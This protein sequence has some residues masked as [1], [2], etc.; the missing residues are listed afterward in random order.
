M[1]TLILMC[2]LL[3]L[4]SPLH[5]ES[6]PAHPL[7]PERWLPRLVGRSNEE[8]RIGGHFAVDGACRLKALFSYNLLK[9]ASHGDL[10]FR[11]ER[12]TIKD[13][14]G[15][16]NCLGK[17]ITSRVVYYKPHDNYVGVD[18]FRYDVLHLKKSVLNVDASLTILSAKS[19]SSGAREV[20]AEPSA[21]IQPPGPILECVQPVS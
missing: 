8:I 21:N 12:S 5:A 20:S 3:F 2:C 9:P 16:Q 18:L 1:K 15:P 17:F 14:E 13:V 7:N 6:A 10:S 19:A 4:S 11:L